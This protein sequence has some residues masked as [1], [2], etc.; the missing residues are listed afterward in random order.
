MMLF[1]LN[2]KCIKLLK[3]FTDCIGSKTVSF[4][5]NSNFI[6][7]IKNYYT[8]CLYCISNDM[9]ITYETKNNIICACFHPSFSDTILCFLKQTSS[10]HAFCFHD[11]KLVE[12]PIRYKCGDSH[13]F[14]V[15]QSHSHSFSYNLNHLQPI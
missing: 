12:W 13:S 7:F 9:I 6:V 14:S 8:V 2:N 5:S 10:V 3:T 15:I 11:G 1:Y 4:S